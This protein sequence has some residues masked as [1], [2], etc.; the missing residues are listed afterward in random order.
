[1]TAISEHA[2]NTARAVL[3]KCA[4]NDPWFPQPA[5]YTMLAWAEQFAGTNLDIDDLLAAVTAVYRDN[6]AGFKPLPADILKSARAIRGERADREARAEREQRQALNDTKAAA[7]MRALAAGIVM[8]PVPKTP[9]LVAA[10]AALQCVVDKQTA[11][12]A[13]REYFAAKTEARQREQKASA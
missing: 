13:M 2:M 3:A 11:I 8:G 7:D 9:D 4:A 12:E 1:M 6:G 5:Q 10:E